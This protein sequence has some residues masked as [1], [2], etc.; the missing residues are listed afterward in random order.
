MQRH[1]YLGF[2]LY[3]NPTNQVQ[4]DFNRTMLEKGVLIRCKRQEQVI[5][6]QFGFSIK[7][8]SSPIEQVAKPKKNTK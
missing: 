5:N 2:Y 3:A 7:R 1:E 8:I 4:R 6:R